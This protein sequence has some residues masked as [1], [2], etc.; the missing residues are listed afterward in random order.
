MGLTVLSSGERHKIKQICNTRHNWTDGGHWV[1]RGKQPNCYAPRVTRN[2]LVTYLTIDTDEAAMAWNSNCDKN[3]RIAGYVTAAGI[4]AALVFI[5]HL[6]PLRLSNAMS[7]VWGSIVTSTTMGV[8]NG[9]VIAKVPYPEVAKGWKIK[10]EISHEVSWKAMAGSKSTFTQ[11]L[12]VSSI[13]AQSKGRYKASTKRQLRIDDMPDG[14]VDRLID[15]KSRTV[16][17]PYAWEK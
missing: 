11:T 14:L 3:M 16:K 4:N 13:D 17:M 12:T 9:E 7:S 1:G 10:L 8:I 15:I 2:T 5:P 6:I